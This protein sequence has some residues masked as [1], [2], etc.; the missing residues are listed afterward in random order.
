MRDGVSEEL[1]FKVIRA[2]FA[3]KRK[4]LGSNLKRVFGESAL[5][6]LEKIKLPARTRAEDVPLNT[7]LDLAREL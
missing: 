1:F 5:T 2:G 3:Q 7:W 4:T 6:A